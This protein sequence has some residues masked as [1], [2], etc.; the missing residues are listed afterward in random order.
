MRYKERKQAALLFLSFIKVKKN[1]RNQTQKGSYLGTTLS[2]SLS[3][4]SPDLNFPS[5]NENK[6]NNNTKEKK[7]YTGNRETK[8]QWLP[9][10]KRD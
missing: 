5:E 8:R 4:A 7:L 9:V 6:N 2:L 1:P 10:N 3:F